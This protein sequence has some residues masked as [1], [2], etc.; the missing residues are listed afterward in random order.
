[1]LVHA[2]NLHFILWHEN[3]WNNLTCTLIC[4]HAAVS[5]KCTNTEILLS[6]RCIYWNI[7]GGIGRSHFHNTRIIAERKIFG[8]LSMFHWC[9]V[10]GFVGVIFWCIVFFILGFF[11]VLK[12]RQLSLY[13]AFGNLC[14]HFLILFVCFFDNVF[15]CLHH[16]LLFSI[17]LVKLFISETAVLEYSDFLL[18]L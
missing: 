17:C 13:R 5:W 14:K 18:L 12:H 4:F 11:R 3:K 7:I 1:M 16:N 15:Y 8:N 6:S 10:F 9:F 2:T